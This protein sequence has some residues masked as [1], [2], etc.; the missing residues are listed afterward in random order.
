MEALNDDEF[1]IN[2]E[3]DDLFE[4]P[5]NLNRELKEIHDEITAQMRAATKEKKSTQ[6]QTSNGA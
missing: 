5:E 2:M 3:T 6:Q 4:T 1:K